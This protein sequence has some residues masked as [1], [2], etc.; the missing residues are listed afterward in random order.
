[1]TYIITPTPGK[2]P[3]A[4]GGK[5]KALASLQ[6]ASLPI[7]P[8][9]VVSPTAF[10]DS[11]T[12]AGHAA[13]SAGNPAEVLIA[14]QLLSPAEPVCLA[15]AAALTRLCPQ[16]ELVAVRS[17]A[18]D[19]DGNEHSFAGQL[20]SFLFVSPTDVAKQIAAVWRSGFHERVLAYRREKCLTPLPAPPAVL[21]QRMVSADVAGVA[22]SADPVSGRRG[23]A[24]VS[25]VFGLGTSLVSGECDADTWRV[26][27][28][29]TIVEVELA[30]KETAHR[31]DPETGEGVRSTVIAPEDAKKPCLSDGQVREVA[32]LARSAA[33]H[34]GRPQDIEW[35]IEG[36]R[37]HLLQSRPITSLAA[38]PDPDGELNIWD[39]SNIAESYGGVTTPL[40]FS[41]A[42]HIYEEVYRQFC[43][44]M[45]VPK[46]AIVANE[47]IFP[48]ML[49]LVRGRVYYNLLNWYRLLA[50]LP[51]FTTNRRF[52][53]QMMGVKEGIP[54]EILTEALATCKVG[55]MQ[56][57]FNLSRSL[58]GLVLNQL[59]L[60]KN[61]DRFYARMN[62]ALAPPNPPLEELRPDELVAHYRMLEEQ[63]LTRWDAPLVNDFFAMVF[64]GLLRKVMATWCGD[65][66]ETLQNDLLSG[67]GGIISAEP[68]KR[69]R[70]MAEVVAEDEALTELLATGDVPRSHA[71][72]IAHPALGPLYQGYLAR[73]GDRCLDELKLESATLLD[74]PSPLLCSVGEFARRIR[75][76]RAL[77]PFDETAL[78]QV[79]QL[80]VRVALAGHPLRRILLTWI[81]KQAR[82]RVR[83]RENLRFE[84]TRLF[85]RVRRI[86]VELGKR[87]AADGILA[88][89]RDI[90]ALEKEEIFGF[91]EGT[92]SGTDLRGLAA[93]RQAE[94]L[95]WQSAEPPS[96]RFDTRGM[97]N[98]AQTCRSTNPTPAVPQGESLQGLGCCPGLVRG[99]ARV[100]TDPRGAVIREGEILVAE[101]TDPG[102]IMLF[103]AC[104]GLL[105][106]RG[107]LLSHSAIVA[108]EMGI[109][110]VVSLA[111]ITA[112][113]KDGD[114]VELDGASGQVRKLDQTEVPADAE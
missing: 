85:G 16:G 92:A 71:A 94:F 17:S 26:D 56:D 53:E 70:E 18:L 103:P 25:G 89:A 90:F 31:A 66:N 111:G 54:D 6:G 65:G 77:A 39:N 33:S 7:P 62:R 22:F 15:V 87:F 104:C 79:A 43:R 10:Q 41:F 82:A 101:R 51:G 108:R 58:G 29:G 46:K 80:K 4:L 11:L 19:E 113:L 23:V 28:N 37:L 21:I 44:I 72:S 48:R 2:S 59:G 114:W 24:V 107:S 20:D 8:W 32:A 13:L 64:Y 57:A 67:E 5:A 14:L 100:I 68:A 99:R 98:H 84:R 81:L 34:F 83:D 27:R 1:M 40:T 93:L 75:S 42:R 63:L 112:W 45:A 61:I 91:V 78:R 109:P 38:L 106:E 96:D 97:V 74:D 73:F 52:M 12:A 55:R 102:W 36:D 88:E 30:D 76:G 95:R 50:L 47:R 49:G 86:F 35:A 110:A 3:A 9:F 60:Q 105:V 69:V